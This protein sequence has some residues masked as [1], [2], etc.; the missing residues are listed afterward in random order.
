MTASIPSMNNTLEVQEGVEFKNVSMTFRGKE[1]DVEAVKDVTLTIGQGEFVCLVG[2]SGCGK[3]TLL[4]LI[5]GYLEPTSGEVLL[6]GQSIDGP[7]AERGVIFQQPVALLP[8]L[9]V[10]ANVGF[11]LKLKGTPKNERETLVDHYLELTGLSDFRNQA[12]YEL[13]GGMQQRVALCR[14]LVNDPR[15]ML[16]DEPFGALDAITREK[17]QEEMVRLHHET[18]KTVM[19]I[20]HSA[21]EAVFLG[22]KVAVMSPR[23]GRIVKTLDATFENTLNDAETR[24]VKSDPMFLNLREEVLRSVLADDS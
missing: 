22:S 5:A 14:V 10:S 8:W 2:P 4:N 6:D 18:K 15:V 7:G 21:E 9:N 24:E 19:L 3:S 1:R 13:S 16:M 20:T 11:G 17:M 23:P 12:I